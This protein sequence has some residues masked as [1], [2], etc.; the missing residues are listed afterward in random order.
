MFPKYSTTSA[1]WRLEQLLLK[2]LLCW[3][4]GKY[5]SFYIVIIF[6]IQFTLFLIKR[7]Y[8]RWRSLW[9]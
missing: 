4:T 7:F 2:I 6:H 3:I 8:Q 5:A 1:F 9:A